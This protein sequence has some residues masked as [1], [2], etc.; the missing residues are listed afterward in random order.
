MF[1]VVLT[2]IKPLPEVDEH[3][4]AHIEY[5]NT[6]YEAGK[7]VLSGRKVPRTGGVILMNCNSVAEVNEL[8]ALDPF[9]IAGVAKY[10]VTEF[11]PTMAAKSCA[12]LLE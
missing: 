4:D 5:L 1:I 12:S 9:S 2:Y 8:I 3:I 6:Y 10:D 11:V 7:F